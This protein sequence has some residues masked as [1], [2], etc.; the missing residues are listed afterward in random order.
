MSIVSSESERNDTVDR[1]E[2]LYGCIHSYLV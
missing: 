2:M 1:N